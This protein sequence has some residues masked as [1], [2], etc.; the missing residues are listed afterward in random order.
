MRDWL[1]AI[2]AFI[3]TTSLTDVEYAAID[4]TGLVVQTYNQASYD[5]LAAVL[6][7]REAVSTLQARLVSFY[8]AKGVDVAAVETGKSNIYLGDVL[9]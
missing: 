5:Q 8:S 7:S 3:G 2:L 6:T 1:N 9:N 4:Q